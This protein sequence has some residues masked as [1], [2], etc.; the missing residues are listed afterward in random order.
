MPLLLADENFPRPVVERLRQA[1]QD[2]LT[3]QEAGLRRAQDERILEFGTSQGRAV[4]TINRFDFIRLHKRLTQHA[5]IIVCTDDDPDVLARK[6]LDALAQSS[7]LAN[8]LIRINL[9]P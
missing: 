1:G 3:V 8:Q 5:G 2:V 4:L 7:S 9:G 6:I